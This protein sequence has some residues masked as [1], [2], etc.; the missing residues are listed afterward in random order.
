M[1]VLRRKTG[2]TICIGETQENPDLIEI[3][4]LAIEG[5]RVKI[6]IECPQSLRVLRKELI[7]N[8]GLGKDYE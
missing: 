2:E 8:K 7:E 4:V 6:G 1:L 5:E 3:T